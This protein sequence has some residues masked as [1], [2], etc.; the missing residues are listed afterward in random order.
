M[1][2]DDYGRD[3]YVYRTK[4]AQRTK[5]RTAAISQTSSAN[6]TGAFAT[7]DYSPTSNHIA[8]VFSHFLLK[9]FVQP[10]DPKNKENENVQKQAKANLLENSLFLKVPDQMYI[11]FGFSILSCIG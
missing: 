6:L 10:T 8:F 9:G 4:K 1:T 11:T 7:T 2:K 3:A 5:Q